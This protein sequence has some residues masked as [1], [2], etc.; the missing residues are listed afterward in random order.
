MKIEVV[1]EWYTMD[2]LL[3]A[4]NGIYEFF[5]LVYRILIFTQ[6]V[7]LPHPRIASNRKT[8]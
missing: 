6:G 1:F 7:Q 2:N 5:L 4:S 3:K 8:A